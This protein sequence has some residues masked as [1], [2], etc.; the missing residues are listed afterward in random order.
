MRKLQKNGL[1]LGE[2]KIE[3]DTKL[4]KKFIKNIKKKFED[5]EVEILTD[6][7]AGSLGY[8]LY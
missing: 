3:P 5:E 4:I 1:I 6:Y 7:E 8:S 2:T